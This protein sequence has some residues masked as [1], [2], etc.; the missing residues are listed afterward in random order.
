MNKSELETYFGYLKTVGRAEVNGKGYLTVDGKIVNAATN[1]GETEFVQTWLV[2]FALGYIKEK[3]YFDF[4]TWLSITKEGSASV[5]VHE[6]SDPEKIIF[7][8][9]P[10]SDASL[11]PEESGMLSVVSRYMSHAQGAT[12]DYRISKILREGKEVITEKFSGKSTTLTELVPGWVYDKYK[13]I[14][15]VMKWMIYCR[16]TYGLRN[17]LED[18]PFAEKCFTKVYNKETLDPT[19]VRFLDLLTNGDFKIPEGQAPIKKE[20]EPLSKEINPFE[21]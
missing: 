8:I 1:M 17:D 18:W 19:E 15:Q 5:I 3:P 20:Q 4:Q 9:N 2:Q 11:T 7:V 13:V 14:P 16:D 10:L 12:E 21:C 6:D